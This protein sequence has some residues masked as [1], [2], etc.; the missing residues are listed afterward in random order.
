MP[1]LAVTGRS[2]V[3]VV[4]S[5]GGEGEGDGLVVV[6]FGGGVGLTV[7]F[8]SGGCIGVGVGVG[9]GANVAK[10]VVRPVRFRRVQVLTGPADVPLTNTLT[11]WYPAA[12]DILNVWLLP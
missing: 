9:F 11:M 7:E 4:V 8:D 5:E 12:A 6:L 3:N 2:I 10:T 1:L